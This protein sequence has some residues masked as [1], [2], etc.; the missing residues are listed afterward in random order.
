MQSVRLQWSG[1][2]GSKEQSRK[3]N[4]CQLSRTSYFPR[5]AGKTGVA[6]FSGAPQKSSR[7][8]GA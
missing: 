7:L 1:W 6:I 5:A 8:A 3:T 4:F 2:S